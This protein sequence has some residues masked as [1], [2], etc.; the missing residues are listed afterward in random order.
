MGG[1]MRQIVAPHALSEFD[2]PSGR[3]YG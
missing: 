1:K 2:Q 3:A